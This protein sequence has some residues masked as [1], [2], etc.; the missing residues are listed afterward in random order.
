MIQ[1]LHLWDFT[2]LEEI[3]RS[4]TGV[5]IRRNLFY[6]SHWWSPESG[7]SL[8]LRNNCLSI[9]LSP[10]FYVRI[11]EY[12]EITIE[13]SNWVKMMETSCSLLVN[14]NRLLLSTVFIHTLLFFFLSFFLSSLSLDSVSVYE[15]VVQWSSSHW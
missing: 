12:D 14:F 8:V 6:V 4:R 1:D 2:N 10:Q 3:D 7:I 11:L 15:L 5:V 13:F 9:G